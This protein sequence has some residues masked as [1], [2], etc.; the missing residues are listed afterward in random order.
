MIFHVCVGITLVQVV[1]QFLFGLGHLFL[2]PLAIHLVFTDLEF[3][4]VKSLSRTYTHTHTHTHKFL[5]I[6]FYI[7]VFVFLFTHTLF[8]RLK[9]NTCVSESD[10]VFVR[11]CLYEISLF[12][13]IL[14]L[15]YTVCTH[16]RI[17]SPRLATFGRIETR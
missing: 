7:W 17:R 8:A 3:S 12:L 9:Q 16:N 11:N 6:Y 1:S 14:A 2:L 15:C 4:G 10:I 5:Y 13:Y